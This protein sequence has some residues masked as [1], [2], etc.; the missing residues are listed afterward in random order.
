MEGKSSLGPLQTIIVIELSSYGSG[1]AAGHSPS[2]AI[3]SNKSGG[4]LI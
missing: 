2:I 1:S 4:K 3:K